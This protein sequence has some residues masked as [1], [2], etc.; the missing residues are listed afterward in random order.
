MGAIFSAGARAAPLDSAQL[1]D[2]VYRSF[3][4]RE[5]QIRSACSMHAIERVSPVFEKRGC[6][7]RRQIQEL[8]GKSVPRHFNAIACLGGNGHMTKLFVSAVAR[9]MGFFCQCKKACWTKKNSAGRGFSVT[10]I[11]ISHE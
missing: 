5:H 4:L 3:G 1:H 11:L 6:V 2:R 9:L 7:D 10:Q 8:N